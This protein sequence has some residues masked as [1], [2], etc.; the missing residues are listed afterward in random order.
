MSEMLLSMKVAPLAKAM[1]QMGDREGAR[2]VA[3]S[4]TLADLAG[5]EARRM[6]R[7]M[8]EKVPAM[9]GAMAGM[10]EA[11]GAMLPQLEEMAEKMKDVLPAALPLPP[12]EDE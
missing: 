11:M 2:K 10:T 4:E 1:E 5:P 9:M 12:A 8:A 7:A 6:P 3:R